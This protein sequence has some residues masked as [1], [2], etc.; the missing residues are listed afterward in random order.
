MHSNRE[1]ASD[2][3][4]GVPMDPSTQSSGDPWAGWQGT[5]A[6][7]N[8]PTG[9][10]G[11]GRFKV[12]GSLGSTDAWHGIPHPQAPGARYLAAADAYS[13]LGSFADAVVEERNGVFYVGLSAAAAMRTFTRTISEPFE[14][15]VK[16]F[17]AKSSLAVVVNGNMY[18]DDGGFSTLKHIAG[19]LG[20]PISSQA[21]NL[22]KPEGIVRGRGTLLGGV[23]EPQMYYVAWTEGPLGGYSFGHGNPPG[24]TTSAVGGLGPVIVNGLKYGAVNRYRHGVPDGAALSGEP[25]AKHKP[26]LEV[27]SNNTYK[28]FVESGPTVG[29][30]VI[31]FGIGTHPVRIVV[32]P[33]G[34]V[35]ASLDSIRDRLFED[36]VRNAVFLDG[37]DSAM[38]YANGKFYSH[39]GP[40]KNMT[41]TVGI[42]F[43]LP[44]TIL[45]PPGRSMGNIA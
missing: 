11:P 5:Q 30:V 45:D 28:S 17:A 15:T 10:G 37:S 7:P 42:G 26:F 9:G 41:N 24:D 44:F 21:G 6:H 40:F 29:K 20:L 4:H 34:I 25:D 23:A 31:G 8:A 32:Q 16:R 38:L 12:A 14:S 43:Q 19:N 18:K 35:N 1:T 33:N 36:G 13:G 3:K 27:R 2:K 39:Q 22:T